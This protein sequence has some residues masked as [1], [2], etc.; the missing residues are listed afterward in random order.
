MADII[1]NIAK[2]RFARYADLPESND[3]LIVVLLKASGLVTDA[4][5]RDYDTLADVLAGA[6]DEADFG[7][8]ARK[9]GTSVTV[10]VDDT[11]DRVDVDMADPSS[12]TATGSSQAV[13]A[14]LVC[15]DSDTTGGTDAN[16]VPIAKLDAVITFDVGVP[17]T[18][19]FNASGFARAS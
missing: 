14:A 8:Y 3:A 17:A 11:N 1:F 10:T 18:L 5:M 15:Y 16:I 4:T 19:S 7:T 13:G 9:T 2:G 6:S 12:Y